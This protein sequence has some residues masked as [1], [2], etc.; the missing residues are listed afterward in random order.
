MGLIGRIRLIDE[1]PPGDVNGDNAPGIR[2]DPGAHIGDGE[3]DLPQYAT[4]G[5]NELLVLRN[6]IE[7]VNYWSVYV[8]TDFIQNYGSSTPG[9]IVYIAGCDSYFMA[10]AWMSP[11]MEIANFI[12][13]TVEIE[14]AYAKWA[15][16]KFFEL[17]GNPENESDSWNHSFEEAVSF[18]QSDAPIYELA[19]ESTDRCAA[20][21]VLYQG[22]IYV[23]NTPP[24]N[25]HGPAG[26]IAHPFETIAEGLAASASS[27]PGTTVFVSEGTYYPMQSLNIPDGITLKGAGPHKTEIH[28]D[29]TGREIT[30]FNFEGA[31]SEITRIQDFKITHAIIAI[32]LNW[33]TASNMI[34]PVEIRNNVFTDNDTAIRMYYASP[35]SQFYEGLYGL[36]AMA[37]SIYNNLFYNNSEDAIRCIYSRARISHN[38]I[39]NSENVGIYVGYGGGLEFPLIDSNIIVDNTNASHTGYGLFCYDNGPYAHPWVIRNTFNG[40]DTDFYC[41]ECYGSSNAIGVDP[42]H[43]SGPFSAELGNAGNYYLGLGSPARSNAVDSVDADDLGRLTTHVDQTPGV[44]GTLSDRGYYYHIRCEDLPTYTPLPPTSTPTVTPTGPTATPT[45]YQSPTPTSTET[46]IPTPT[47]TTLGMGYFDDF[48]GGSD[49]WTASGLWHI[50][51]SGSGYANTYSGEFS[52]RYAQEN[53]YSYNT[54]SPNSGDLILNPVYIAGA[55]DT[56]HALSFFSWEQTEGVGSGVDTRTV[57]AS[58]DNGVTWDLIYQSTDN[59]S[60]WRY[61]SIPLNYSDQ[62]VI[63]KFRFDTVD[64]DFNNFMGWYIDDVFIGAG[65]IPSTNF[66]GLIILLIYP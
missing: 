64:A 65:P 9:G 15:M 33:D 18:I 8:T 29:W 38:T 39:A 24:G 26:S 37:P 6:H 46:P 57:W 40:S 41:E 31:V 34:C 51:A 12:G 23:D 20:R 50:P 35:P 16:E 3:S 11:P 63:F 21:S 61:V 55:K 54:G 25:T 10:D 7:S 62:Y 53:Q 59:S 56:H 13:H 5:L 47:G 19:M 14:N 36:D 49:N 1:D 44:P 66:I 32:S 2:G 45:V 17:I 48:E 52:F 42:L 22:D 60:S 58:A 27:D 4:Y 28:G 43:V 30:L